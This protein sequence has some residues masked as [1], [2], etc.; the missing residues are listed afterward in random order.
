MLR[1]NQV[2][3]TCTRRD[4]LAGKKDA[5]L[6]ADAETGQ[7]VAEFAADEAAFRQVT[8]PGLWALWGIFRALQ[9]PGI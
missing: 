3:W 6:L 4:V 7:L 2:Q 1:K 8:T 5:W 9:S